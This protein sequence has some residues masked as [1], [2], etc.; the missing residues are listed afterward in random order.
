[1]GAWRAHQRADGA[2][3]HGIAARSP[4]GSSGRCRSTEGTALGRGWSPF[5]GTAVARRSVR[6][7]AMG[8]SVRVAWIGVVCVVGACGG[9][10]APNDDGGASAAPSA[11][12]SAASEETGTA[13][14]AFPVCPPE[15][16][17]LQSACVPD[18]SHGCIYGPPC[19]AVVCD[20]TGHWQNAP[21]GC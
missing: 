13:V 8:I 14:S 16:P 1:M 17:A 11:E 2:R 21:G 4:M 7:S 15:V 18:P 9:Q 6:R 10:I 20:S 12:G 19:Q 3:A 5:A